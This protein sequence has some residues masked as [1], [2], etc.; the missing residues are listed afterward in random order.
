MTKPKSTKQIDLR[1]VL[2]I[3]RRRK[4]LVILPL[5]IITA[6]SFASTYFL[7][8]KYQSFT[9]IWIDKPS[10]VSRELLSIVGE[11]RETHDEMQSRTLALQT[12]ITSKNFLEQ[13]IRDLKLDD[14][15]EITRQAY[16]MR[17]STP[18]Y[19]L[20]QIRN[21]ILVEKLRGQ[22]SVAFHGWD[23]IRITV[24]SNDPVK[25]R[26]MADRLAEILEREKAKYEMEKILDN[27]SFTDQQLEKTEYYYQLALDSLN[28]A[29]ARLSRLQLPDNIAAEGNQ[30]AI[31]ASLD[32]TRLDREDAER[33]LASLRARLDE[34]SLGGARLRYTDTIVELRTTIDGLISTYGSMTEQ[35]GWNE[36]NVIDVN[37][38]IN[39]NVRQLEQIIGA[40]VARQYASYPTNQQELLT[41][42][43]V[44][45][46]NVDILTSKE[47][48]L[49]QPLV[50]LE[51][52]IVII[53][54][55]ESEILELE[56]RVEN[57]RR[58][59]DAFRSEER[60]AGILSEQVKDRVKYKVIEPAQ[61][62]LSPFW[63]D[64]K[65]I[66]VIGFVLGLAL[67]AVFVFLT[68]LFDN[69][70][71]KVEDVEE[72]LGVKVL[73]TIPRIDKLRVMR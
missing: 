42:Y 68:E 60:T 16:K 17:E 31:S 41:R 39:N 27:Q 19:S 25:A 26:D 14:D 28:S 32:R 30:A 33:D 7:E 71:R 47:K 46:E 11:R 59:R 57:A 53:P 15:P 51:Q 38:R 29:R 43:F 55:L 4:W 52:R 35:Y 70:F 1:E 8:P 9:V 61:L 48:R 23:Q 45:Q 58:Y 65:K 63:P 24:E 34:F 44:V 21:S 2:A 5:V 67:G 56:N 3:V 13:L 22:I 73:A 18:E 37:I 40:A 20:E 62:P 69:S 49:R 72:V 36:Q 64:K 66:I 54:R 50:E 10:S 12:E 6:V